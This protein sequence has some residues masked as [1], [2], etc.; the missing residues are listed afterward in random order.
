[1]GHLI[2]NFPRHHCHGG[3]K[4]EKLGS[5]LGKKNG[6]PFSRKSHRSSPI[7]LSPIVSGGLPMESPHSENID[8]ISS[9]LNRDDPRLPSDKNSIPQ[10]PRD[11]RK[12]SSPKWQKSNNY[13]CK[14]PPEPPADNAISPPIPIPHPYHYL[15]SISHVT[16]IPSS[17]PSPKQKSD[18]GKEPCVS[19]TPI[20]SPTSSPN[21]VGSDLDFLLKKK[22]S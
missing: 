16:Y 20:N 6:S 8:R 17:S 19:V 21:T 22:I 18:H 1:M 11:S 9:F 10:S 12:S 13:I 14:H 3:Q 2:K 5:F 7:G 4:Q 15:P